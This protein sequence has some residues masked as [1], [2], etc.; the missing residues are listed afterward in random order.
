MG[1]EDRWN[2]LSSGL[3]SCGRSNRTYELTLSVVPRGTSFH[4]KVDLKFPP[5]LFDDAAWLSGRHGLSGPSELSSINPDAMHD[6]GQSPRQSYDRLFHPAAPS[7]L[8]RPGLEP[9]PFL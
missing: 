4:H 6:Y 7:D 2:N 3:A 8:H 9:R 5:M 1:F